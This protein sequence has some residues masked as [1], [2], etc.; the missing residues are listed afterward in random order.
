MRVIVKEG[1]LV[2]DDV[3]LHLPNLAFVNEIGDGANAKVFLAYNNALNRQEAVKIWTPRKRREAVDEK[4]FFAKVRKN[5]NVNFPNVAT[6]YDADIADGFY[7]ARLQY[8]PGKS[9]ACF[10]QQENAR[11]FRYQILDTI[12]S[13]ML[14]VY[15][16]GYY[17]GDLHT[18]NVIISKNTPYIID[19]G[20]SIFSGA[21]ASNERDCRML[22]ELCFNVWPEFQR[23]DFINSTQLLEQGSRRAGEFLLRC[24]YISWDCESISGKTLDNYARKEWLLRMDVLEKDF[25][26]VDKASVKKF[27]LRE[28]DRN[29]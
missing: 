15:D 9:L 12:L 23:L 4:Q 7:Y 17:H 22:I 16:A 13:T 24:L 10:L 28:I 29:A 3:N 8:I 11:V 18:K 27:L 6:L 2:I 1:A 5:A 25:T 26:F 14:N 19:F 21:I 20:T